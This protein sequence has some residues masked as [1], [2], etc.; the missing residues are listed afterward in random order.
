L[1]KEGGPHCPPGGTC[2][3]GG[4]P[5]FDESPKSCAACQNACSLINL[6]ALH[7]GSRTAIASGPNTLAENNV[8]IKTVQV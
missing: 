1:A 5:W 8:K 3:S 2:S 7:V 4:E 6:E